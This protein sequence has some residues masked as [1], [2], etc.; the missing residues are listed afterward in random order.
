MTIHRRDVFGLGAL[1][2]GA[3]AL[4]GCGGGFLSGVGATMGPDDVDRLLSELDH[5]VVHLESLDTKPSELGVK[6]HGAEVARGRESC[7]GL[8]T[9]LCFMGTYRDVPEAVWHEPRVASHLQRTLPRIQANIAAAQDH[10]AGMSEADIAEIDQRLVDDP[11]LPMRIM[12]RIDGYA[13]DIDVPFDQ[14]T[15]LRLST[16][17]LAARFRH[18]GTGEVAAKLG[19]KYDR[20][21]ASMISKLGLED[22]RLADERD[23][24]CAPQVGAAPRNNLFG[25]PVQGGRGVAGESCASHFDCQDSLTCAWGVCV[26]EISKSADLMA[27][28]K[29][30]AVVGA[31]LLIPPACAIGV[32]VLLVA[33]FMVIVAGIL[34]TGED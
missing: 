22:Q 14:R 24:V 9:T 15:Y 13:K 4:E 12:E 33:L 27:T 3:L 7:I 34:R 25:V 29:K 28:S 11:D 1:S 5:V 32:L 2:F 21:L 19:A 26:P 30:V 17:Q 18:E 16:A 20:V 23:A 8:L 10:L 31:Y 6:G